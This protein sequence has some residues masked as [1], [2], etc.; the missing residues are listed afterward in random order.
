MLHDRIDISI[1]IG[2][3]IDTGTW[4]RLQQLLLTHLILI[5]RHMQLHIAWPF[6]CCDAMQPDAVQ[7]DAMQCLLMVLKVIAKELI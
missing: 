6:D 3:G 5:R 2:I 4:H 1:G 7:P